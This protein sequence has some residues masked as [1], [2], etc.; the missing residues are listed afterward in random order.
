MKRRV[1]LREVSTILVLGIGA[2]NPE[3]D[4]Q[5][6]EDHDGFDVLG[7]D[8]ID[9]IEPETKQT[10]TDR[11]KSDFNCDGFA[12]LAIGAT[13][14][15][16]NGNTGAVIVIYG[17][18]LGLATI[19]SQESQVV[20][21]Q[22]VNFGTSIASGDFDGDGCADL[23][24]GTNF[25]TV[26]GITNAGYVDVFYGSFDG[27]LMDEENTQT[28]SQ[29]SPGIQEFAEENDTF[30]T[31]LIA[32]RFNGDSYDDLAIGVNGENT[33]GAEFA[34]A[35]HIIFGSADRLTATGNQL[36]DQGDITG[37][38]PENHDD[39]GRMLAAGYFNDDEFQD[40]AVG[41]PGED[42]AGIVHVI[43]G[44]SAGLS[45][46]LVPQSWSQ[47]TPGI[48]DSSEGGDRF[49]WTLAAGD[50]NADG[51]D[52]LTVG[53][54]GESIGA[55]AATGAINTIYGSPVGLT[56][57]GDQFWHQNSPGILDQNEDGDFFG[58]AL[59]AGDFDADGH[60]DLGVG[61]RF[62][63]VGAI[64]D[65]GAVSVLYG[66]GTGLSEVGD[67][68]WHQNTIGIDDTSEALDGYGE[69]LAIGDFN[70]D[71]A[72]D[73]AI[74]VVEEDVGVQIDAGAVSVIYGDIIDGLTATD[75]FLHQDSANM[76]D[77]DVEA[78]DLFGSGLAR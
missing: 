24:V 14:E 4:E 71:D 47:N 45:T 78:G 38:M 67:Q 32:G 74:G 10:A 63:N 64:Q 51:I 68:F 31:S 16:G 11:L 39:F 1:P 33:D 42:G 35:V 15:D 69:A 77:E 3:Y 37:Q 65:A 18:E 36:F 12:D 49:G 22:G 56:V 55:A 6:L 58:W 23:A 29:D 46:A 53:A 19:D 66:S 25:G 34:G 27:L 26:E 8:E 59:I 40:L 7:P 62:E 17:S 48:E 72:A 5:S 2:C 57:V 13:G 30:G 20:Y 50:F 41:A 70:G 9:S 28:W 52:D 44:E 75:Q 21:G 60:D 43:F 61:V 73:L 76:P 54:Y